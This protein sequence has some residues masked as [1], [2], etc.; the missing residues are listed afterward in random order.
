MNKTDKTNGPMINAIA[1]KIMAVAN[2]DGQRNIPTL[3]LHYLLFAINSFTHK[4]IDGY[5]FS[6]SDTYFDA[7]GAKSRHLMS[8]NLSPYLVN[9]ETIPESYELPDLLDICTTVVTKSYLKMLHT[10]EI[11]SAIEHEFRNYITSS[12]LPPVTCTSATSS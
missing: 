12:E 9:V 8:L 11:W 10:E 6:P 1:H 5:A 2:Q 7:Q 3:Q 4:W